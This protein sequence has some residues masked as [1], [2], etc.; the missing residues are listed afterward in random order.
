M[1][2]IKREITRQQNIY[3]ALFN[4]SC[5]AV[6]SYNVYGENNNKRISFNIKGYADKEAYDLIISGSNPDNGQVTETSHSY[7]YS[8]V[9]AELDGETIS[10]HD[11][12][13]LI[14]KAIL[15][16]AINVIPEYE[17]GELI[18]SEANA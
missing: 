12:D 18:D 14:R 9:I 16:H 8:E 10:G 11:L 7:P 15:K 4:N 17:D 3:K 5:F 1:F 13:S 2:Y 6:S